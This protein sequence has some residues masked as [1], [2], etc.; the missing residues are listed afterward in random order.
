MLA[1]VVAESSVARERERSVSFREFTALSWRP[2]VSLT[3][4]DEGPV[5]PNFTIFF[6]LYA[7]LSFGA[8]LALW[9]WLQLRS[10][11]A[12]FDSINSQS[13]FD[14][15]KRV[16]K[17]NMLLALAIMVL[18]GITIVLVASGFYFGA[19]GWTDL[20]SP[21][22]ILGLVCSSAGVK[23]TSA[24]SQLKGIA[25]NNESLRV[26]FDHVVARWTSSAFPDW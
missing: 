8:V 19:F 5:S 14:E 16:V 17:T 26:D 7:A 1:E 12:S 18:F 15:F 3:L 21:L 24:E 20:R 6:G 2:R 10:F 13:E 11:L 4:T 25:L 23:L 9:G 22:L